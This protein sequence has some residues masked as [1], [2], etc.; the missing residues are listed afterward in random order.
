VRERRG[1]E[2]TEGKPAE[3]SLTKNVDESQDDT[4]KI[5]NRKQSPTPVFENKLGILE[6]S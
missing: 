4:G 1:R 6:E 2:E 3:V 5:D